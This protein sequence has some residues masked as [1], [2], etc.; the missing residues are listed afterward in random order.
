M[1]ETYDFEGYIDV[2]TCVDDVN[3]TSGRSVGTR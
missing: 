3:V 2:L 1:N